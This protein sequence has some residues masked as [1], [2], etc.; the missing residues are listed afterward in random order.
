MEV[1]MRVTLDPRTASKCNSADI[2]VVVGHLADLIRYGGTGTEVKESH[3]SLWVRRSAKQLSANLPM[4]T[5]TKV[6][7]VLRK[8]EDLGIVSS[9]C[10]SDDVL[11]RT[12]WYAIVDEDV[13]KWEEVP[14]V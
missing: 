9:T 7:S 2:A 12:K 6:Q 10:L 1:T 8:A 14:N 11:D 5:T 4:F 3:G 13:K